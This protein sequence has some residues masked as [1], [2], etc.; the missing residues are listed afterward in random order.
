[1][2][3]TGLDNHRAGA[4]TIEEILPPEMRKQPGYRLRIEP[5][6]L[7]LAERLKGEGYRTLMAGKWHLGHGPGDLPNGQGFDWSLALDASGA[8]NWAAKPYMPYYTEAP[9]FEDGRPARLPDHFY[10]SIMPV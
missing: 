9:W 5:E 2:L 6:V 1:M 3:L 7:T 8:D 10:S 4:A